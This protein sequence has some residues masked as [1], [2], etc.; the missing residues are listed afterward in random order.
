MIEALTPAEFVRCR[1]RGEL[2]Q[3]VDVRESWEVEIA[4]L[5]DA[6]CIPMGEIIARLSE[7]D[8]DLPI[9]VLCHSGGRS[10]RVAEYLSGAGYT[11]VANISGGIDAWSTEVDPAIPRY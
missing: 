2:W 8:A 9:A 1:E 10:M 6:L 3:L 7:L 5:D 4:G 11:R